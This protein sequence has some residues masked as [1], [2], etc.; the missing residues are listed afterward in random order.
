MTKTTLTFAVRRRE[1]VLVGPATPTPRDTKR[2]SD[3]DDQAVLRGHVPFVFL[4]R[5]GKGVRADDPA[6][7]IRRALEAALVPFYPL[8]GRVR[9]VEAR[10]LGK[11]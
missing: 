9:E 4:Y 1:P 3:I 8:A 5:G 10:K 11:Q 2:L 6:T 7:V